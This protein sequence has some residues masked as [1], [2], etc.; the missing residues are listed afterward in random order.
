MDEFADDGSRTGARTRCHVVLVYAGNRRGEE[1]AICVT[2]SAEITA[3]MLRIVDPFRSRDPSY[4]LLALREELDLPGLVVWRHPI[5]HTPVIREAL[6][7]D[8]E[9][10]LLDERTSTLRELVPPGERSARERRRDYLRLGVKIVAAASFVLLLV[11]MVM[12][13]L[14]LLRGRFELEGI[15]PLTILVL[16]ILRSGTLHALRTRWSLVPGGVLIQPGPAALGDK[17]QRIVTP[18]DAIV[19]LHNHLGGQRI[20]LVCAEDRFVRDVSDYEAGAMLAA[21]LSTARAPSLE[22]LEGLWKRD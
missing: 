13:P 17:A 4:Q 19:Y 3:A 5:N 10:T 21:W 8:F 9:P 14:A 1:G 7:V 6:T 22:R 11:L 15:I 12:V 16:L 2:L 20:H 18:D